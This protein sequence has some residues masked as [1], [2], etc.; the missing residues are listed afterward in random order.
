MLSKKATGEKRGEVEEER[1][2]EMKPIREGGKQSELVVGD[3]GKSTAIKVNS[4]VLQ[5]IHKLILLGVNM[6]LLYV[7][8]VRCVFY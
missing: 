4:S 5:H 6:F 2:E 1:K 8:V 3:R 7:H